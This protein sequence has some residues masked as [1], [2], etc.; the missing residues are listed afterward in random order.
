M[1]TLLTRR[2]IILQAKKSLLYNTGEPWGKKSS[3]GLFDVTMGSFDGAETRELVGVYLLHIVRDAH[4]Y[5][6]LR[7]HTI[8]SP[9]TKQH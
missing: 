6:C 2:D 7:F 1:S 4:D 3:S 8:K 5:E 9:S